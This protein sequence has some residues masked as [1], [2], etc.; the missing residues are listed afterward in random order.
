[1]ESDP[2]LGNDNIVSRTQ[3]FQENNVNYGRG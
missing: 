2:Q 3:S 1:M